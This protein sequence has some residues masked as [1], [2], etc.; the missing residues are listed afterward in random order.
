MKR[1]IEKR[2]WKHTKQNARLSIE[3]PLPEVILIEKQGINILTFDKKIKGKDTKVKCIRNFALMK[4][5]I[6]EI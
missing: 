1:I 3:Q 6:Q 5:G 2:T 4:N